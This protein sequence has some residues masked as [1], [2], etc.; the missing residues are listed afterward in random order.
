MQLRSSLIRDIKAEYNE[1]W[2]NSI[3]ITIDVDWAPD[4][5]I[6][7]TLELLNKYN[8][9]ATFFATH[10]TEVFSSINEK[11]IEIGIH[12]NFNLLLQGN[13]K[14]GENFEQVIDYYLNLYPNSVSVR[15]HSMTQN[16]PI[17]RAFSNAGLKFDCNHFFPYQNSE[18]LLSPF[19]F[20]DNNL[21]RI[22]YFWEDDV[23]LLF[24]EQ[25]YTISQLLKNQGLKVFDFHPIHIYLNTYSID[26][27][28]EAKSVYHDFSRL[29]KLVNTK[30]KG[31][32]D[33]F[34]KLLN[35][36]NNK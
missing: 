18:I 14:Y 33:Y 31:V 1:T 30:K 22:P 2:T 9:K 28:N 25:K 16:T 24:F 7:D 4:E 8:C 5:V 34:I 36:V 32:R 10:N 21:I 3:F 27:Y 26:H 11:D 23:N 19:Y 13:N 12:P 20:W 35:S 15:S 17:L 6:L 29:S